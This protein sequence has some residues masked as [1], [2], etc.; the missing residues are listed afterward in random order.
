MIEWVV[1]QE[2]ETEKQGKG[3]SSLPSI[4]GKDFE[5]IAIAAELIKAK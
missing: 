1:L 5:A 4:P 2:G 3:Y